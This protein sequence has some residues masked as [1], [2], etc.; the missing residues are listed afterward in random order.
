M[1]KFVTMHGR[2]KVKFWLIYRRSVIFAEYPEDERSKLLRIFGT[3][4]AILNILL[5]I[6]EDINLL[7]LS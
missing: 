4:K 3:L 7:S 5:H 6:Q 1:G 2:M